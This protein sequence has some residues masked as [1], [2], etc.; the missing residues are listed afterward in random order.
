MAAHWRGE[1]LVWGL[2]GATVA[3]LAGGVI[4]VAL[5]PRGD[6]PLEVGRALLTL[7]AVSVVA[8]LVS[9]LVRQ[10]DDR[11][12]ERSAWEALLQRVITANS[13]VEVARLLLR[14]DRTASTYREQ[15]IELAHV[16][17]SLREVTVGQAIEAQERIK[18]AVKKMRRYLD[19]LGAEYE[20]NY[21][22]VARQQRL[23]DKQQTTLTGVPADQAAEPALHL[24]P[25]GLSAA[26]MLQD[27]EQFPLLTAFLSDDKFETSQFRTNYKVAKRFLQNLAGIPRLASDEE[28]SEPQEAGGE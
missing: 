5:S 9:V 17:A 15:F 26:Q 13:Q 21:Q 24:A 1:K 25:G 19:T 3:V 11:R 18:D 22:T 23:D 28:Q 7:V 16:R 12:A 8:G 6:V 14:A 20:K 27:A 10:V 4:A 2:I